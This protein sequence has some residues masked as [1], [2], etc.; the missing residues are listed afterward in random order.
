MMQ[1]QQGP[2]IPVKA[3]PNIYTLLLIIAIL[4]L[5]V[6]IG[7]VLHNLMSAD[8]YGQTLEQIFGKLSEL[9]Q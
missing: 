3:Q 4:I 8:R 7:F 2:V 9:P 6:T 5:A 1:L